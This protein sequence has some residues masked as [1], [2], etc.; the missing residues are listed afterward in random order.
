MVEKKTPYFK[1]F[2][3]FEIKNEA[4]SL[5][6]KL[7]TDK[8]W[9]YLVKT[10]ISVLKK[11]IKEKTPKTFH[12]IW[13]D[14]K[15]NN[16]RLHLYFPNIVL[17]SEYCLIIRTQ[18]IKQLIK[19]NKYKFWNEAHWDK[20]IDALVYKGCGLR[21]LF[22]KKPGQTGFYETNLKKSTISGISSVNK[23]QQLQLTS[24]RSSKTSTTLLLSECKV[25]IF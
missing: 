12:Y 13:S 6:G 14:R 1:L 2:W 15:D 11:Y 4:L 24:I 7:D 3:D 22:Q 21:T 16:Y 19:E 8:F 18:L 9:N 23:V 25:S 5:F 20:I 17:N 10:V